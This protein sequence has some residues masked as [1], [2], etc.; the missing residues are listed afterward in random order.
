MIKTQPISLADAGAEWLLDSTPDNLYRVIIAPGTHL[1]VCFAQDA[2]KPAARFAHPNLAARQDRLIERRRDMPRGGKCWT[3]IAGVDLWFVIPKT[4]ITLL[5][6]KGHSY[7]PALIAGVPVEFNVS[8][9]GGSRAGWTDVLSERVHVAVG[10]PRRDLLRV[11]A[12]AERGTA[13]EAKLLE[14]LSQ[15]ILHPQDQVR[16]QQLL[17][18]S[19][20]PAT[21]AARA[22]SGAKD[23]RLYLKSA[24]DADGGE[25]GVLE[26]I[27]YHQ[28]VV[29]RKPTAAEAMTRP[30][31]VKLGTHRSTR[32]VRWY[33]ARFGSRLFLVLPKQVDWIQTGAALAPSATPASAGA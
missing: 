20:V 7:V 17:A 6:K 10:H 3:A 14:K 18:A 31:T 33:T 23:L 5:P 11:A 21:L 15:S 22:K 30:G 25:C 12:V 4:A 19:S 28:S 2:R 32:R 13:L 27:V 29:W 9:G 24:C 16:Y 8:G 26:E 1:A